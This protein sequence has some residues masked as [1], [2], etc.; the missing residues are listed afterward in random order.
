MFAGIYFFSVI[1]SILVIITI[2]TAQKSKQAKDKVEGIYCCLFLN[3]QVAWLIYGNTF[4]YTD[5][6]M[7]CKNF[8]DETRSCWILM[9]VILAF[10]YLVFLIWGIACCAISC[11]CFCVCFA[12]R[13]MDLR[14]NPVVDR[15]PYANAVKN[16]NK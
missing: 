14:N 3:F 10:G 2:Y 15:I 8:N 11:I 13:Q 4:H 7:R 16:L 6:G 12:R 1:K 5:A 9:M